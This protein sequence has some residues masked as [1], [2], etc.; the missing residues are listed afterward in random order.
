MRNWKKIFNFGKKRVSPGQIS[1]GQISEVDPGYNAVISRLHGYYSFKDFPF[2]EICFDVL[3]L[4]SIFNPDVCQALSII[5]TLGN[6]GHEIEIETKRAEKAVER[7]NQIS[8][9]IYAGGADGLINHLLNQISL[10]GALSAEWV[11]SDRVSDG[12]VRVV[13]PPV[14]TIRFKLENNEWIAYQDTGKGFK[15]HYVE[16]NRNTYSYVPVKTLDNNPYGIPVMLAAL[17]NL[18][19]QIDAVN[20]LAAVVRKIG[21]LGV[22]TVKLQQPYQLPGEGVEK[23]HERLVK[24]LQNYANSYAGSLAEGVAVHYD[25]QEISHYSINQV[26]AGAAKV[27]FQ[28]NEEQIMSAFD[29]PPSMMGRSYSTTETYAGVDYERLMRRLG[30]YRRIIKRFIEKG[31]L[32]DLN[33]VGL[34]VDS[35]RVIFNEG[36]GFREKEKVE[37]EGLEIDNVIKKRDAGFISDDEAAQE[38][39]YKKA[40]GEKKKSE[41]L[42]FVYKDG[43]YVFKREQLSVSGVGFEGIYRNALRE[44][45]KNAEF[46]GVVAGV[47]KVREFVRG[48]KNNADV[49]AKEVY[50]AFCEGVKK[51]LG[52][53]DDVV[54]GYVN[55]IYEY[56]RN[57]DLGTFGAEIVYGHGR[58]RTDKFGG[59]YR[60]FGK[61]DIGLTDSN[62]VR[63]L[64]AIDHYYFGAGNYIADNESRVG[65]QLVE[66]L[67]EE[68]LDKGLSLKDESA[69]EIFE[70]KFSSIVDNIAWNKINQLVNTTV[71]RIQ[72]FGQTLN[73]YEGGFTK[74]QIVGPERGPICKYC[75]EMVGRVFEVE[76]AAF[77]LARI[78]DKGFESVN[79]LS[80]FLTN[81]YTVEE[82]KK[83]SDEALQDAGFESPPYH[84]ECRH[85]KAAYI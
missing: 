25:D 72:N 7:I 31:Y 35:V 52:G 48:R 76:K 50:G 63:Y 55:Q 14:R 11:I 75:K 78:V 79:D 54:A 38:L 58:T 27:V 65:K 85:R 57:D 6:A 20:N 47:K 4:L 19:V 5:T 13:A 62:A 16:L 53:C 37:V 84:P 18:D 2:S 22:T 83:M 15:N 59:K 69:V 29:I 73:L 43:G 33:L 10:M 36:D 44:V 46:A 51:E 60:R 80:P 67:K 9:T 66:W 30:N 56:Y 64:T 40:S 23:Y 26:A 39:G 82:I 12:V 41:S 28:I 70:E 71:G 81:N 3:E 21:M 61:L 17:K 77:R 34:P 45:M 32:L 24:H 8:R 42:R 49:F 1:P 74:Y 68:Y